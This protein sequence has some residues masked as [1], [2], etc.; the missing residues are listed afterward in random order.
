M[1]EFHDPRARTAVEAEPYDHRIK[2]GSGGTMTVGLLANGFP[3]SEEFLRAIGSELANRHPGLQIRR[4]NKGNATAP[5]SEDL[6]RVISSECQAAI[7]A[8]GH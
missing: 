5:A 1:I 7:A 3:D 2:V 6:I 8:Y 4:Y